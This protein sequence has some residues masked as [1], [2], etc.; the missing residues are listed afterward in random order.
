[1]SP[2]GLGFLRYFIRSERLKRLLELT[3]LSTKHRT[4][5]LGI[6]VKQV[7]TRQELRRESFSCLLRHSSA[8]VEILAIWDRLRSSARKE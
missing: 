2:P 4:Q 7:L 5:I 1:M 8:A 6:P 3:L